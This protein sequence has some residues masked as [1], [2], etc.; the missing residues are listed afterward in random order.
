MYSTPKSCTST[1]A[2]RR[3]SSSPRKLGGAAGGYPNPLDVD[4]D[5][6]PRF[7]RQARCDARRVFDAAVVAEPEDVLDEKLEVSREGDDH[8]GDA[9]ASGEDAI[10]LIG[11]DFFFLLRAF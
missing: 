1:P 9:R 11:L 5:A 4:V 7:A 8:R 3:R 6:P 10:P 2:P